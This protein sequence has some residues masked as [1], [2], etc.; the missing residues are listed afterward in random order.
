MKSHSNPSAPVSDGQGVQFRIDDWGRLVLTT[1]GGRSYPGVDPV[2]AFPISD[3]GSWISFTDDQGR[4]VFCLQ[5][6]DGLAPE[7]RA[8][9]ERELSLR[10][11]IPVILRVVRISGESTPCDWEVESDHG[12]TRFTL[13][14]EDDVRRLGP[15]RVMI[16]DSRKLRYQIPDA[17]NLDG[18]SRRLLD[19]FT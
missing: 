2:R 11:L 12:Q 17:R 3:P 6:L 4:E 7:A 1:E 13:D 14:S 5:S 16:V 10:E 18:H 9:L 8:F 19:R 15:H